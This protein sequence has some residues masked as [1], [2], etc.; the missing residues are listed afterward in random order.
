[1]SVLVYAESWGGSFRKSTYE[2]VSYASE[3]AKLLRTDV[4]ALTFGNESDD[5]LLKLENYGANKVLTTSGIEKGDSKAATD[6]FSANC[7][8]ANMIVFPST[9]TSKMIAPRLA[10]KLVPKLK[11]VSPYR[12][13][14]LS[15]E[16]DSYLPA[17]SISYGLFLVLMKYD[18]DLPYAS[19]DGR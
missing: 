11:D 8:D 12:W 3:T 15:L 1:M 19:D 5:E 2:A 9:Y 14:V 6:L 4:I 13:I 16:L 17:K 18:T 10:A 7:S